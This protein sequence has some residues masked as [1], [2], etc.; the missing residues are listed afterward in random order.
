LCPTA[1]EGVSGV[2]LR[3]LSIC[4]GIGGIELGLALVA[5]TRTVCYVER[6]AYA[7][8]CLVARMEDAALDSAPIWSDLTTFDATAW[9]GCVDLV[10]AGFPCQPHSCAGQRKGL[11]D[12]RWIWNDIVRIVRDV[13]PEIVLLENVPGLASTGGLAA[14]LE[15]LASLGFD[16]EWGCF[17]AAAVGAPHLRKRLF[18]LAYTRRGRSPW[19]ESGGGSRSSRQRE[20]NAGGNG[21]S[22]AESG[23]G[24]GGE[25]GLPD[26]V[27]S[28]NGMVLNPRFVEMLMGYLPGWTD[29][30][31]SVTES[32]RRWQHLH[33]VSCGD[34]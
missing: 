29:C 19:R 5:R 14:V 25:P 16:A 18:I 27:K 34:E 30:D 21:S 31:A 6:D 20:A 11:E 13:G 17:S 15:S 2:V 4:S 26:Q 23:S 10:T 22:L 24:G 12:D 1:E 9:R 33:G 28:T 3:T 8:A 7:A 32:F